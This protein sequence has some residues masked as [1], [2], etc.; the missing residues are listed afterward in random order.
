MTLKELC[1]YIKK[2]DFQPDRKHSYLMK[3]VEEVGELS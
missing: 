2:N 3:L 1:E